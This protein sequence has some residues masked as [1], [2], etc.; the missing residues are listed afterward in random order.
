MIR[1]KVNPNK[2]RPDFTKRDENGK[3][4]WFKVDYSATDNY[5]FLIRWMNFK[6]YQL[7]TATKGNV[8]KVLTM[9]PKAVYKRDEHLAETWPMRYTSN[10]F[11][12]KF[13]ADKEILR[14][15]VLRLKKRPMDIYSIRP[16]KK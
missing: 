5:T 11:F 13:Y 4:R 1:Y 10:A 2:L 8:Q 16:L 6:P 7:T 3:A 15:M 14:H 9:S 12:Y